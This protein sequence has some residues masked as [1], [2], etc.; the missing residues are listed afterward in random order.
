MRFGIGLRLFFARAERDPLWARF[1]AQVWNVGGLELPL[2]DIDKG[3]RG[4]HFRVPGRVAAHD[5]VFGGIR[6]ALHRIGGGKVPPAYGDQVTATCL[7]ALGTDPARIAAVLAEPLPEIP[8]ADA[9]R[10]LAFGK[11]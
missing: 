9:Q 1:V 11:R 8:D 6:E 4:G 3:I 2:R 5:V 7:Q 10:S